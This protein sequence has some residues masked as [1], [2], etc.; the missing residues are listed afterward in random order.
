[1]VSLVDLPGGVGQRHQH[2]IGA[3]VAE[4]FERLVGG[5]LAQEQLQLRA[6]A[7][8]AG[9]DACGSRNGAMVGMTL[10]LSSPTSGWPAARTRSLSNSSASRSRRCALATTL[11]PS[12]VKRTTRRLRSTRRHPEQRFELADAGGE[13]GLRDEA[14]IRRAAEM[15]VL[16]QRHQILQLLDGGQVGGHRAPAP[17][18][19]GAG[20]SKGGDVGERSESGESVRTAARSLASAK[21]ARPEPVEGLPFANGAAREETQSFE[22]LWTSG[23]RAQAANA[24]ALRHV[25]PR[26]SPRLPPASS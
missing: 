3:A 9:Q 23:I 20:L 26:P 8:Q 5:L 22:K 25:P 1:M 6:L 18:R 21:S 24:N 19:V 2:A 17:Y 14:G 15:A 13:G 7:A 12:G 16:V 10:I 4:R 11:S